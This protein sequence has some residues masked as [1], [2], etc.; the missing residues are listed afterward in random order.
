MGVGAVAHKN[1]KTKKILVSVWGRLCEKL[2]GRKRVFVRTNCSIR[3]M[4]KLTEGPDREQSVG[5]ALA[6]THLLTTE[7]AD[8]RFLADKAVGKVA[9][10]SV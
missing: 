2:D 7:F 10:G 8:V 1:Q 6:K 9:G 4:E 5:E 3:R